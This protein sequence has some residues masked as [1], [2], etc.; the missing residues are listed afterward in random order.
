M[1]GEKSWEK[2]GRRG[3]IMRNG[4]MDGWMDGGGFGGRGCYG[5]LQHCI[6]SGFVVSLCVREPV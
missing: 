1:E 6:I 3:S 2:G 4:C 5:P